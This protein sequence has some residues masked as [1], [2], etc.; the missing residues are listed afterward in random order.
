VTAVELLAD[1]TRQHIT[2]TAEGDSIRVRP[3]SRLTA[4]LRNAIQMHKP[5]L[6]ALLKGSEQSAPA[7]IWDQAAAEELLA[8]LRATVERLKV[9]GFRGRPP[10][11]F[12]KL[13]AD[14]VAI[15]EGHFRDHELEAAR[16]WDALDLLR[17]GK[18]V[19]L[20]IADNILAMPD[21][22]L[23]DAEGEGYQV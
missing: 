15:A 16:G 11:L 9:A 20:G 18:Q 14:A 6:L 22:A 4:E 8:D 13:A 2:L 10:S 5:A 7:F 19:L 23:R 17:E 21:Q 3:A 1:L 12:L